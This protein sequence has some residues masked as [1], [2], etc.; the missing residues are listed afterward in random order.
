MLNNV[1]LIGYLGA[2]AEARTTR[3]DKPMAI[4]SLATNR[5]WKDRES[6]EKRTQVTWHRCI[7][8]GRSAEFAS[9]LPKGAHVQIVGEIQTRQYTGADG[10]RKTVSEIRVHQIARLDRKAAPAA[11]VDAEEGSAA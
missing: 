7:L 2:D 10:E 9:R 11:A 5:N 3:N 4:L 1:T 6:G 8:F